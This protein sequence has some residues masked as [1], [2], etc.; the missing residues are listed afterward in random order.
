MP[1]A[2]HPSVG[3]A[4]LLRS[5]GRVLPGTVVQACGAGELPLSVPAEG[6]VEL[7]GGP[8]HVDGA[9]DPGVVLAA[10]GLVPADLADP[11]VLHVG[12]GL[13]YAVAA[14]DPDALARCAP[15]LRLLRTLHHPGQDIAPGVYLTSWDDGPDS[16]R[17]RMFA[18]D[19]ATAEDPATGSAAL[20]YG[21]WL[22]ETGRVPAGGP[23]TPSCRVS[24]WAAA[25][26]SRA[27]SRWPTAPAA[28]PASGWPATPSRSPTGPSQSPRRLAQRDRPRA[29]AWGGGGRGG[30]GPSAAG[31]ASWPLSAP[32]PRAA[33]PSSYAPGPSTS[34][35]T[36]SSRVTYDV[37]AHRAGCAS[38]SGALC[39]CACSAATAAAKRSSPGSSA[40]TR[41]RH[42]HQQAALVLAAQRHRD[43]RHRAQPGQL[44]LVTVVHQGDGAVDPDVPR[45]PRL[46]LGRQHEPEQRRLA[47]GLL[48][49]CRLHGVQPVRPGHATHPARMTG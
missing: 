39:R 45:G 8:P 12:T 20:A 27:G 10:V 9:M 34:G 48:D 42:G 35:P 38:P 47:G 18:G 14:V 6:P 26:C 40:T 41:A 24:R 23:G 4:W 7:E 22:A 44:L 2:G 16:A 13:G 28:P 15:D 36:G 49:E 19:L 30:R 17:A 5:L 31:A 21:V 25:R 11:R 43:G 29:R 37:A 33:T 3:T 46:R 1:F 32:A